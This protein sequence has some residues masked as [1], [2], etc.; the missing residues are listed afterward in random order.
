MKIILLILLSSFFLISC[1]KKDSQSSTT[2]VKKAVTLKTN[3]IDTT[4]ILLSLPVET[5]AIVNI[6]SV[7]SVFDNFLIKEDSIFG[8]PFPKR[9]LE[10]FQKIWDINPFNLNSLKDI[11]LELNKEL[12]ISFSDIIWAKGDDL[13]SMSVILYVPVK[14]SKKLLSFIESKFENG[15]V[16]GYSDLNLKKEKDYYKFFGKKETEVVYFFVKNNYFFAIM[17]PMNPKK[18]LSLTKSFIKGGK[19]LKDSKLFKD[20]SKLTETNSGIYIY[21]N[22]NKLISSNEDRLKKEMNNIPNSEIF[23]DMMKTYKSLIFSLALDSNDFVLNFSA[24]FE[25]NAKFLKFI[26]GVT[27]DNSTILGLDKSSLLLLSFGINIPEYVKLIK[28]FMGGYGSSIDDKI[29]KTSKEF[30]V[31]IQKDIIDNFSGNFAFAAYDGMSISTTSYN[32]IATIGFKKPQVINNIITKLIKN[33]KLKMLTKFINPVKEDGKTIYIINAMVTQVY[34]GFNSKEMI[35]A[36]SKDMYKSALKSSK[37]KGFYKYSNKDKKLSKSL[38]SQMIFY[39]SFLEVIK[40]INNFKGM[41]PQDKSKIAVDVLELLD[42][43]LIDTNITDS[44]ISA[45]YTVKTNSKKLFS[46]FVADLIK[47]NLH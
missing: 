16:K 5:E 11:G 46:H 25:K 45:N 17:N 24:I 2:K 20:S 35:I 29:A 6:K 15:Q 47:K 18:S 30:G 9:D 38:N 10:E 1:N 4:S 39:V 3:K 31:D 28:S 36:S 14:D 19:T 44:V 33:P 21:T 22:I 27:Y 37:E 13:S 41:L 32:A 7:K 42:Y 12:G 8:I 43:M 34:V 40:A 26:K 23:T